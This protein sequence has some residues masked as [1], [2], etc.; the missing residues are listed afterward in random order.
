MRPQIQPHG[1]TTALADDSPFSEDSIWEVEVGRGR[2]GG[3][4][5]R[6]EGGNQA[7]TGAQLSHEA[8]SASPAGSNGH[9]AGP[10][11]QGSGRWPQLRSR[12]RGATGSG[13]KDGWPAWGVCLQGTR[14]RVLPPLRTLF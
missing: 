6:W 5:R 11:L 9:R 10:V 1:C 14:P 4:L 7:E 3:R 8:W 2:P 12:Q 13:G